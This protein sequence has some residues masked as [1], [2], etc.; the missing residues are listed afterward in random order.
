MS[1]DETAS[2]FLSYNAVSTILISTAPWQHAVLRTRDPYL[3]HRF[4]VASYLSNHRG[5][6][7]WGNPLLP[8]GLRS[9]LKATALGKLH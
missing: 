3:D 7:F 2:P 9:I 5:A 6:T 8:N 4:G 1:A